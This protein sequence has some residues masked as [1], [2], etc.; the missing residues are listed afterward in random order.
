LA[1]RH[2]LERALDVAERADRRLHH[3]LEVALPDS[4]DASRASPQVPE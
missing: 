3:D 1:R 4:N 2:R